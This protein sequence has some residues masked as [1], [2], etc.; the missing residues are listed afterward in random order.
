MR[1]PV[2]I[3]DDDPVNLR[4]LEATLVK[5]KYEVVVFD[6]PVKALENIKN[7]HYDL[8]ILDLEMPSLNGL[9]LTSH[10]RNLYKEEC[11]ILMMTSHEELNVLE[12][13]LS[14][15][16]DDYVVKPI[17]LKSI[18]YKLRILENQIKKM[19]ERIHF[20]K[21]LVKSQEH[22][23]AIFHNSSIGVLL[24]NKFGH[25]I[26]Y[27]ETLLKITGFL[28]LKLRDKF[29]IHC[30]HKNDS[31]RLKYFF[32][33]LLES[34]QTHA[35]TEVRLISRSGLMLICKFS[36]SIIGS[37]HHPENNFIMVLVED[38][39]NIKK[40]EEELEF[41][42]LHDPLTHLPNRDL[43][44]N[45]LNK[46][47][48]KDMDGQ[49][50]T[51]AVLILDIDRFQ[52]I[53]ETLG[54]AMGDLLIQRIA[55]K[56]FGLI[57]PGDTI[58]RLTGDEFG[59]ITEKYSTVG[60]LTHFVNKLQAAL[61]KPIV[62]DQQEIS[63]TTSIGIKL[64]EGGEESTLNIIRD[65]DTALHRAKNKGP[66]SYSFFIQ[67]MTQESHQTLKLENDLRKAIDN[68][69]LELYYQ[70]QLDLNTNQIS[71]VEALLRWQHPELG[72]IP[73]SRFIPIAE[74]A[75]IIVDIGSWVINEALI[76]C[77]E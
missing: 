24:L 60:E 5:L 17:H 7:Y 21:E 2:L 51:F 52:L 55:Q 26:E 6:D 3:V 11:I 66:S 20:Q 67:K 64:Y 77:K 15:G 72:E 1:K 34:H 13:A 74:N 58:A 4:L 32:K 44:V 73:P 68:H 42:T 53:N 27:N 19:H 56:L 36:V 40:Y 31:E 41:N 35:S 10:I 50:N 70:P 8:I 71:G 28:E 39:T 57:E 9:L 12:K 14:Q 29:I 61:K 65:A 49:S 23:M 22:Y 18:N 69:D 30:I 33:S 59:I 38:L 37:N 45:R 76:K 54:H 43:F 48:M 63:I 47:L 16:V 62:M 25:I 46:L 75:G